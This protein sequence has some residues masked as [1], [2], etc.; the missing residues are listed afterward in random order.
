M[1]CA[2]V[3]LSKRSYSLHRL[4][5]H[6]RPLC[7]RFDGLYGLTGHRLASKIFTQHRVLLT[8]NSA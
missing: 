1:A 6:L 7:Q 4:R 3:N 5:R 2:L 8:E